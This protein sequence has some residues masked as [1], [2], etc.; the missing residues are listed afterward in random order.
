MLIMVDDLL[1]IPFPS[2]GFPVAK[3]GGYIALFDRSIRRLF[4][5]A[6]RL[7]TRRPGM[8]VF[9]L[10][11]LVRQRRAARARR[12]WERRGTHVP[13]FAI[14]SI[15][16]RCNLRC[17]GC[18]ARAHR[19]KPEREMSNTRLRGLFAEAE[20][21]GISI[22]LIAGGEPLTRPEI[23]G[24]A[25]EFPGIIF[26]LFTNGLLLDGSMADA[27]RR[28]RHVIPVL[29]LE[30]DMRQTDERRGQGIYAR[31]LE[32]M[33]L[34]RERGVFFGA[35]FTLT[36]ENFDTVLDRGRIAA[37]LDAGCRLFFFVDYVPVQDGTEDL[38]LTAAQ[39]VECSTRLARFRAELPGLFI[40]LP[41]DEEQ[42][43]GC[44][45]AGRGFVHINPAGALE[46]CPFAPFSDASLIG[47]PLKEALN[48]PLL[49][50]IR[51][52]SGE[53]TETRGGCALWARRDWVSSLRENG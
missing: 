38:A 11:T 46:P 24:I 26:P 20:E 52:H 30:G 43:G 29:S 41:G 32:R 22:V 33:A 39:R 12:A 18:Y 40:A 31:I 4:L 2:G 9:L 1:R 42:Y 44:L 34:L 50:E 25:A 23:L 53:L 47:T 35:S 27:F 3:D 28:V 8:A 5:D 13:P 6:L 14:V 51:A 37:M 15:T 36:R 16:H 49:R 19:S 7:N 10:R 17:K 45:A 21:L 48:S